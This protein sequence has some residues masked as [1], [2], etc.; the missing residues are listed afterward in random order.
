MLGKPLTQYLQPLMLG[1]CK[2]RVG[3]EYR[4]GRFACYGQYLHIT[5]RIGN[6][7]IKGHAA[8][9]GTVHIARATQFEVELCQWE[10]IGCLAHRFEACA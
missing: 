5:G 1:S 3:L 9:Q 6:L 2:C 10:T 8:L 4:G 7:Q